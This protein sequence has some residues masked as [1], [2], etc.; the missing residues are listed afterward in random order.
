EYDVFGNARQ[1]FD[2]LGDETE[3]TYDLVGNLTRS[4]QDGVTRVDASGGTVTATSLRNGANVSGLLDDYTYDAFGH[5]LTHVNAQGLTDKTF[6]DSLGRVIESDSDAGRSTKYGY[7]FSAPGLNAKFAR[8]AGGANYGGWIKT[9]TVAD[10]RTLVD[11][12][13]Y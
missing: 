7:A 4:Q 12:T 2:A 1:S 8:A 6:Y 5:R 9:T 11:V 3:N 13:D 10:N